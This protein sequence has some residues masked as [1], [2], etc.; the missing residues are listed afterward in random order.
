MFIIIKVC[1]NGQCLNEGLCKANETSFSCKC[2]N[3]FTGPFCNYHESFPDSTILNTKTIIDTIYDLTN[4]KSKAWKLIYKASKHG[5]RA[6]DFHLKCDNYSNTFTLIKTDN[7]YVFGGYTTQT[8]NN[9]GIFGCFKTDKQ[10]FLI[11][12]VNLKNVPIKF[13]LFDEFSAIYAYSKYGPTFGYGYD[14]NIADESNIN[15]NSYS[16][17]RSYSIENINILAGSYKF[18]T[19]D[20]ETYTIN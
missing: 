2:I 10:A 13:T 1:Q 20:I 5:F 9:C 15:T 16:K 7:L 12:L 17:P 3:N 19:I 8:W 14:L 11:S 4:F 18:K 6:H